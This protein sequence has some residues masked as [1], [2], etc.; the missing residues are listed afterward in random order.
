MPRRCT[1]CTREIPFGTGMMYVQRGGEA[2][3]YC[4]RR[5]FRN[6]VVMHK[7]FNKKELVTKSAART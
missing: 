5:C 6:S 4:S 1:Y 3:F 2:H 7:R